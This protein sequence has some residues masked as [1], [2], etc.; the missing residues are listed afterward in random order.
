MARKSSRRRESLSR[1]LVIDSADESPYRGCDS[2]VAPAESDDS[3]CIYRGMS[4]EDDLMLSAG[5]VEEEAEFDEME[6]ALC[7]RSLSEVSPSRHRPKAAAA[8]PV[9]RAASYNTSVEEVISIDQVSRM[10]NR[11]KAKGRF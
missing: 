6:E 1:P 9:S 3:T 7:F 4:L 5:V 11:S 10:Y 2:I 8:A